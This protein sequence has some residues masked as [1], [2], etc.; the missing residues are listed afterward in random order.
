M[1]PASAARVRWL[2][3]VLAS[4]IIAVAGQAALPATRDRRQASIPE[5]DTAPDKGPAYAADPAWKP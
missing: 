1:T 3:L 4:V 5:G 2:V